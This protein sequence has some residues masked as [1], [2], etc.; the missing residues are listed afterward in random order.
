[1]EGL[2]EEGFSTEAIAE[3]QSA[4]EES[5]FSKKDKA[6]LLLAE[7]LTVD[8]P[9]AGVA[10]REALEAGWSEKEVAHAIFLVSYFNMVTRIANAFDLPPDETHPYDPATVLPMMRC[11]E[12]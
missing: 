9:S 8:P 12:E 6:L 7:T 1:V 3:L 5:S 2:H 4:I 11:R 10:T